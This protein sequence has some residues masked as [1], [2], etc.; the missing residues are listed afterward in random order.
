MACNKPEEVSSAGAHEIMFFFGI[1]WP[2]QPLTLVAGCLCRLARILRRHIFLYGDI[3]ESPLIH[4]LSADPHF[5]GDLFRILKAALN[6]S[7]VIIPSKQD[8]S[9]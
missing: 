8:V 4:S 5:N 1:H 6:D 9:L 2:S 7:N 3:R